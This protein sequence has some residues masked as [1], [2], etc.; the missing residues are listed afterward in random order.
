MWI[1]GV[2]KLHVDLYHFQDVKAQNHLKAWWKCML[3]ERSV[4]CSPEVNSK[5]SYS[6]AVCQVSLWFGFLSVIPS[7]VY[8]KTIAASLSPIPDIILRTLSIPIHHYQW[9]VSPQGTHI[10]TSK[11]TASRTVPLFF[12]FF[13]CCQF[14][15]RFWVKAQDCNPRLNPSDL[16]PCELLG[17]TLSILSHLTS[18]CSR[19]ELWGVL[20]EK[21]L[22]NDK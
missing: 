21:W 6:T 13:L 3:G 20:N 5:A 7:C 16:Y 12:L 4:K 19:C 18:G 14:W 2:L 8:I 15:A 10:T 11:I 1:S 17:F 9:Q 22:L